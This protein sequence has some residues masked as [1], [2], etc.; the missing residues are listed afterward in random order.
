MGRAPDLAGRPHPRRIAV[1]RQGPHLESV[2]EAER[3]GPDRQYLPRG[4]VSFLGVLLRP[5][6]HAQR[7]GHRPGRAHH[8]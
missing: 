3:L 2:G 7:A 4:A 5:D 6:I 8:G 1:R